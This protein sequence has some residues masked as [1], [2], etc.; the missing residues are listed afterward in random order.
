M[1]EATEGLARALRAGFLDQ[2]GQ[3]AHHRIDQR[4]PAENPATD[5]ETG[6]EADDQDGPRRGLR[7]FLGE[8]HEAQHQDHHRDGER[9]VLRVHEHVAVEGRAQCEQQQRREAGKRAADAPRQPPCHGKADQADD[10]AEQAAGFEQFERD[11]LVQQR[12]CHVEAAAIHIEIGERQ[13]A[14]IVEAGAEHAQQKVGVFG[15][16]VVVPA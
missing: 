8:A 3:E 5:G 6:A 1:T 9:R 10:G 15:V 12:G 16:G 2:Q 7:I 13:R 14:G 11:D 4:Q